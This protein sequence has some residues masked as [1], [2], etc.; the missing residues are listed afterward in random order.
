MKRLVTLLLLAFIFGNTPV[1]AVPT[2]ILPPSP[3]TDSTS[4]VMFLWGMNDG[5]VLIEARRLSP[6]PPVFSLRDLARFNEVLATLFHDIPQASAYY[7][8]RSAVLNAAAD[9]AGELAR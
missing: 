7:F 4:V 8:G 1:R 9:A 5:Y 2:A 3:Y 6:T